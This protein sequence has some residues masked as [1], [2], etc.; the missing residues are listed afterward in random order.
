MLSKELIQPA[1]RWPSSA[2]V[3][4]SNAWIFSARGSC[5]YKNR[6]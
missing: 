3:A 4:H 1:H 5:F 6:Y 2:T